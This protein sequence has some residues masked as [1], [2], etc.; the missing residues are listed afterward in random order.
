M[1]S[2]CTPILACPLHLLMIRWQQKV[3]QPVWNAGFAKR[4]CH[5]ECCARTLGNTFYVVTT[6]KDRWP[7][8]APIFAVFVEHG[9]STQSACR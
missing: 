2:G 8:H 5:I 9:M 7:G 1:H 6:L 4:T 3:A